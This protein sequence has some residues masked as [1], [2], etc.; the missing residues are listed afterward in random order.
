MKR[1]AFWL[2]WACLVL[3]H[4]LADYARDEAVKAGGTSS[5]D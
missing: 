1:I 4:K 3:G 2:A 5:D